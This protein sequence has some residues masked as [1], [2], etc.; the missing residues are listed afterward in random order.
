MKHL[1]DLEKIKKLPYSVANASEKMDM[2][3][4]VISEDLSL[5]KWA[6]AV[7]VFE[8]SRLKKMIAIEDVRHQLE[9]HFNDPD[10]KL[11][12]KAQ[13]VRSLQTSYLHILDI[14]FIIKEV[15]GDQYPDLAKQ[16]EWNKGFND[17]LFKRLR[18]MSPE[19]S[20]DDV[21]KVYE[22]VEKDLQKI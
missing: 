10:L 2:I 14:E 18:E 15:F 13:F 4:A 11:R 17:E 9:V 19:S 5:D 21:S 8:N 22:Q 16:L 20:M 1:R 7:S 12:A 3:K 6:V